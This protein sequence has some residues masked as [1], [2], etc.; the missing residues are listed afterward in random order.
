MKIVFDKQELIDAIAPTLGTVS[1]KNTIASIEGIHMETVTP[2][3][4][5]DPN[6]RFTTFDMN[7]GTR[8]YAHAVEILEPGS[9]IIQASR[10]VPIIKVLSDGEITIAVDEKQNATV[11]SG[12]A[13]FSIASLPGK[14]F[15]AL[16]DLASRYRI[17]ELDGG[18]LRDLLG[19]VIHSVAE[20]DNRPMLCGAFLRIHADRLEVVSC[21][22][23]TLSRCTAACEIKDSGDM[24]AIDFSCIIPGH[25]LSELCHLLPS[26]EGTRVTVRTTLKYIIFC[27]GS[28]TYFCRLMDCEYIDYERIIP[29]DQDIFVTV[30]RARLSAAL[31]R[32]NLIA[33]EKIQ[34][35]AKSYVKVVLDGEELCISATTVNGKV[36]EELPIEHEGG[37]L[38]IAFN[39][40]YLFNS[41]R[42]TTGERLA[43]AFKGPTQSVIIRP[44]EPDEK[45]DFFYMVLPVRVNGK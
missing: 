25:G 45:R 44:K 15:P 23:Y 6:V 41:V 27:L 26:A 42:V 33:E 35:S 13:S 14:D 1:T 17:F 12:R 31:E 37:D 8:V 38:E 2:E 22:S 30:D 16:P 3:K 39:S 9:V 29:H 36:Y 7:K 34:G 11:S 21:D 10:L 5:G 20:S 28:V 4:E 19:R 43:L 18:L 24:S 32:A 40:R